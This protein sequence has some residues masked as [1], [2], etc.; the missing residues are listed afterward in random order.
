MQEDITYEICYRIGVLSVACSYLNAHFTV[1][2]D[3]DGKLIHGALQNTEASNLHSVDFVFRDVLD[4]ELL[5]AD[6]VD[7]VVLNSLFGT[8]RAGADVTVLARVCS[9]LER[10][11]N[12]C[13]RRQLVDISRWSPESGV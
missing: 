8:K 9:W 3:I 11:C 6:L 7:S 12:Q 1:G 13:T 10:L 4:A 5:R 2:V